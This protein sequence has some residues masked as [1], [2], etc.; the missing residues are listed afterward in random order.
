M[1]GGAQVDTVLFLFHPKEWTPESITIIHISDSSINNLDL[2]NSFFLGQNRVEFM[3]KLCPH[4]VPC[5]T[6]TVEF[7]VASRHP[8]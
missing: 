2:I 8:P 6:Y 7:I 5:F 1:V 4:P 3:M